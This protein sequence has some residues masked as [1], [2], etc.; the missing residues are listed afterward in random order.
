MKQFYAIKEKHPDKILFFRMGDFYEMFG[1]DAV[2]AAPIL[3]VTLT[4]RSHG[5]TER[6]PLAGVPY[7]AGDKYLAKLLAAGEKVVVVEQV[8]D[9]KTAKGIV[10]R[11]IVEILTPGTATV[12]GVGDDNKPSWLASVYRRNK[13]MGLA[14][15]DLTTGRFLIDE[16]DRDNI[17]QR[18][19][20]LEP[21]EIIYPSDLEQDDITDALD[22]NRDHFHLTPFDSWNY[23]YRTATRDLNQHFNT[24]TLDG[25][26]IGHDRLGLLAAGA[27]YRY[28]KENHR[29]QLSHINRITRFNNEDFMTLDY[30]TVRNLELVQSTHS[31][32]DANSLFRTINRC[33]SSAGSRKLRQ[34]L[35]QPFISKARIE[36][37]LSGVTELIKNRDLCHTL[38]EHTRKITDLEKLAGRL[39]IG[40]LTPR[41]MMG[42][43]ETLQ[44]SLELKKALEKA[45][46][47]HLMAIQNSL[48]DC[49][50]IIDKL[51]QALVD[52]PPNIINKGDIIRRGYS[53]RLDD[54]NDSIHGARIFI[55]SLPAKRTRTHRD[56]FTQGGFQQSVWLLSGNYQS[57]IRV[58][59][60]RNIS[61]SKPWSTPNAISRRS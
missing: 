21:S 26:G 2:H 36:K 31:G 24:T 56:K 55:G 47:Q 20:T 45:N 6:I 44:I 40:K 4:S 29:D 46:T 32:D 53:S 13:K 10:K 38:R 7:H 50:G 12:E 25:F 43:K 23:D 3:G 11:D 54:L 58:M 52:D 51:G 42:T 15:L 41:Q 48:P 59:S 1:E 49:C 8:E 9:P 30:S 34:C 19:K 5:D 61:A 16:G 37:R 17:V 18:I 60:P 27:I 39:G 35:L 14:V 33:H 22:L 57:E 28:L